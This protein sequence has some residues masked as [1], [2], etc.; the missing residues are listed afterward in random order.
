VS[1]LQATWWHYVV[2]FAAVAASWAGVPFI[3]ATAATAAA[4]A[5]SHGYFSLAGVLLVVAVAGEVGGLAGYAIGVRWGRKLLERP[6]KRQAGRQQL[7]ERGERAYAK[8][9][10]LAVFVTPAIVSGTARMP[11][12]QFIVWNFVDAC[13]FA[14]SIGFSAY[15][16]SQVLSGDHAAIDIAVLV[17]GLAATALGVV[18]AL[19]RR[20]RTKPR[21]ASGHHLAPG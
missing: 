7:L 15:G 5:A 20:G 17:C 16:V 4:V 3:G 8:W 1:G 21:D 12:R 2:V 19:R 13:L 9:G 18:V 10:R 11:H 14:V 6:G